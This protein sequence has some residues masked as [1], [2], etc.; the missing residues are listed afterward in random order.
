MVAV[1]ALLLGTSLWV[2]AG[3]TRQFFAWTIA[4]PT[5]ASALGGF[6]IGIGIYA[7]AAAACRSWE[8]RRPVFPPA[9][10]GPTL[11]LIPT[12][13]HRSLFSFGHLLA[14][15]WLIDYIIFPIALLIV[16]VAGL[17]AYRD[18]GPQDSDV[19]TWERVLLVTVGATV[20]A[21]GFSLLLSPTSFASIW[22][23]PLTP[24]IGQVYGCWLI[25]GAIGLAAI[26]LERRFASMRLGLW[27]VVAVGASAAVA[28]LLHPG[29]V[30]AGLAIVIWVAGVGGLALLSGGLLWLHRA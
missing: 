13:I 19:W 5:A 29:Q 6:Y 8:G 16:Y 23:W 26:G 14:W 4:S 7:A 12:A 27:A 11:L 1:A 3:H 10:A 21:T 20:G 28:P 22:P 25:A 30:R 9:I 24:L 17:R 15:L 18:A 2:G